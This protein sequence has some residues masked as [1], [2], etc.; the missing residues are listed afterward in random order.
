MQD[1]ASTPIDCEKRKSRS[2]KIEVPLLER[3]AISPNEL[4]ALFGRQTVWG[5]R[6]IYAGKVKVI[7][8]LGRTMIPISE[9]KRLMGTA[10]TYTGKPKAKATKKAP[11]DEGAIS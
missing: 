2:P 11:Q 10:E 5:Y 6:L 3:A 9:V 7:H 8:D 4:A 1:I